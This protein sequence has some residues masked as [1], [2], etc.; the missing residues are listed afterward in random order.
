[1]KISRRF[2]LSSCT[3][4]A[5][6]TVLGACSSKESSSPS[7]SATEVL[8]LEY[9]NDPVVLIK[10]NMGDIRAELFVEKAPK[11]V[12]NFL[13]YVGKK[14]FDNTIFHRVISTFMI[15][16][17]GFEN[18]NGNFVEKATDPPVA[19]ESYNGLKNR[20]GTLAMAR[21]GDPHSA[22]AQFFINTVDN[23][24]LN[25]APGAGKEGYAVFGKVLSGMEVVD[26]IRKVSTAT[27]QL[28][29]RAPGGQLMPGPNENVP[30]KA[31]I[32]N[33]IT[34]EAAK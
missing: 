31:V 16:G 28:T 10:T 20:R 17:G 4:L 22:T 14:H 7:T 26:A 18:Q 19:N 12:A 25:L 27:S 11:T 13:S 6:V 23:E 21:T 3:A 24:M 1:M 5:A 9:P 15:Q 30:V 34:Q 33:S 2:I 29:S 32:I 8:P